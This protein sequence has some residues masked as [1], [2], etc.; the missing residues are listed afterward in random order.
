MIV[1]VKYREKDFKAFHSNVED[2]LQPKVFTY[3]WPV[4]WSWVQISGKR[5]LIN[6]YNI[7]N[8]LTNILNDGMANIFDFDL[9]DK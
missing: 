3:V 7:D 1:S 6:Y 2:V 4:N 9:S 5:K 8:P